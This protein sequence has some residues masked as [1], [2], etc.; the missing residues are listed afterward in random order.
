M[1]GL[2]IAFV[3]LIVVMAIGIGFLIRNRNSNTNNAP[4]WAVGM[5]VTGGIFAFIVGAMWGG[6]KL[7]GF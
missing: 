3:V 4:H 7:A 6:L 2:K 1:V 5:A